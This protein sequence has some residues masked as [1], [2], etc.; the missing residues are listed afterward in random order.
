MMSQGIIV[1]KDSDY[2]FLA[3]L[4]LQTYSLRI[5]IQST[6]LREDVSKFISCMR[7]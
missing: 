4:S 6:M 2:R 1:K 3:A 7:I 5:S